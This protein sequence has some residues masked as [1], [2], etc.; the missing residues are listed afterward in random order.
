LADEIARYC[1]HALFDQR[2]RRTAVQQV[3]AERSSIRG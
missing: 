1:G 2:R 3:D